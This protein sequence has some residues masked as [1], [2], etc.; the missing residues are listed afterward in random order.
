LLAAL[1]PDALFEYY[2]LWPEA[3]L[4]PGLFGASAVM[5]PEGPGLGR[6]PDPEVLRRYRA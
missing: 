3:P 6:D 5:M 2:Y 4:Y 1:V